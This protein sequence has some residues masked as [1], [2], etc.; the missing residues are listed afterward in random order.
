MKSYRAPPPQGRHPAPTLFKDVAPNPGQRE[1]S[2]RHS[3]AHPL[4]RAWR[5]VFRAQHHASQPRECS[6]PCQRARRELTA[7]RADAASVSARSSCRAWFP[8]SRTRCRA[9]SS[10]LSTSCTLDGRRW[11]WSTS[12][13]VELWRPAAHGGQAA[14]AQSNGDCT[15]RSRWSAWIG[16]WSWR[17]GIAGG[18]PVV[19]VSRRVAVSERALDSCCRG[20][21]SKALVAVVCVTV[22]AVECRVGRVLDGSR[23]VV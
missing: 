2:A 22:R 13:P 9:G 23:R 18:G 12:R 8:S 16:G 6:I 4:G 11:G 19:L 15:I 5:P 10:R 1:R 21:L 17:C 3:E 20:C 14:R 7:C